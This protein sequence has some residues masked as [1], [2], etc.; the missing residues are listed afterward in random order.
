MPRRL[1]CLLL[2]EDIEQE[3]FFRPILK[4]MFGRVHVEARKP[5][6]GISFVFRSYARLVKEHV[7]RYPQQ[8]RGIVVV[9][10]GDT[11]GLKLRLGELDQR[12]EKAGCAKRDTKEKIAA[13]VST[14]TVETWELWLCGRRDLNEIGDYKA[15]LQ[16]EKRNDRMISKKAAQAWFDQLSEAAEKT[17]KD[18]LPSLVAGRAELRRLCFLAS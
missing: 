15:D 13:L 14:K 16:A 7:R 12:L 2:C 1:D 18:R 4:R 17:E 11:V 3:Q 8:A 6:A 10:D 9:V 5:P